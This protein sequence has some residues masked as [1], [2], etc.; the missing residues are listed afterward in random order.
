M[1]K[2]ATIN[3]IG[4]FALL[5]TAGAASPADG[6]P[7]FAS[8]DT[9]TSAFTL[10]RC[11]TVLLFQFVTS[12]AGFDTGIAINNTSLD[13]P[14]FAT[15]GQMGKCTAHFFQPGVSVPPKESP[16]LMPG[17]QCLWTIW[18][19]FQDF[20]AY[21]LVAC[22]FQYA[23]GHAFVSNLGMSSANRFTQSYQALVLPDRGCPPD[24]ASTS[25]AGSGEQLLYKDQH[26][27]V[28]LEEGVEI[29]R[30]PRRSSGR[31]SARCVSRNDEAD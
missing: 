20:Q 25:P 2:P 16:P 21:V 17:E 28:P 5:S 19:H 10:S 13:T 12:S 31:S 3:V 6:I 4:T 11:R 22:D 15:S 23:H 30:L 1:S 8:S 7:R 14:V 24:P 27:P 9:P 29:A 18:S 26:A